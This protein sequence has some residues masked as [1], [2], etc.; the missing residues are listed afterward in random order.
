MTV[1]TAEEILLKVF[2]ARPCV[3]IDILAEWRKQIEQEQRELC[4]EAAK[5]WATC[6]T[7][8]SEDILNAKE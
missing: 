8:M 3:Q 2:T 4:N 5:K 1:P 6:P 7:G